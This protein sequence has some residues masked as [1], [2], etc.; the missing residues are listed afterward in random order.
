MEATGLRSPVACASAVLE[1]RKDDDDE[2]ECS[3]STTSSIGK[4][5]DVSSETESGENEAQS[6]Y[7]G[8]LD[9][10]ESLQEVLPIRYGTT[11]LDPYVVFF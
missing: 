10:M 2:A 7:N 5:S 3:S 9:M 6:A 1:S 8:P 11:L 4:N